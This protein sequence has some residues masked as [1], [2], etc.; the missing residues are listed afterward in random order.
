MGFSGSDFTGVERI[1][2]GWSSD[3]VFESWVWCYAGVGWRRGRDG[4]GWVYVGIRCSCEEFA[5]RG[6]GVES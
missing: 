3:W 6:W 4:F 2:N 1:E 5:E